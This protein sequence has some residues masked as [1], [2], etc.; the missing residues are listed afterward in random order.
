MNR[1]PCRSDFLPFRIMASLL[2]ASLVFIAA[3]TGLGIP[4]DGSY[5]TGGNGLVSGGSTSSAQA[6]PTLSYGGLQPTLQALRVL[7]LTNAQ[8]SLAGLEPLTFSGLLSEAAVAHCQDMENNG[9]FSH[10]GSDGSDAGIRITRTGYQWSAYGE[11]I[12]QGFTTPEDVVN[13]WM[14]SPHHRENILNS[15]FTQLGVGVVDDTWAQEFARPR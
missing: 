7:D 1:Y 10:T 4:A 6:T 12:A 9:F 11:N 14:N 3:C 8:R 15:Q 2:T 13:A 5:A